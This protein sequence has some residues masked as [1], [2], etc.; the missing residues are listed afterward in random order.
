MCFLEDD[1]LVT[2]EVIPI[3]ALPQMTNE[4]QTNSLGAT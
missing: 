3:N 1:D 4:T 2:G